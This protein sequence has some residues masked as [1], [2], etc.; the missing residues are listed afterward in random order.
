VSNRVEEV[1]VVDGVFVL[2][3]NFEQVSPNVPSQGPLVLALHERRLGNEFE[4]DCSFV[5]EDSVLEHCFVIH[6]IL[7]LLR[8]LKHF[9]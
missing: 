3:V 9:L 8:G 4:V 1:A 2:A 6:A 5:Y 7:R